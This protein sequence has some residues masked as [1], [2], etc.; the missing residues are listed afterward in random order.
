MN[1][2]QHKFSWQTPRWLRVLCLTLLVGM[3]GL[4]AKAQITL[5]S[6]LANNNG[7]AL[8]IGNLYNSNA[9]PILINEIKC[10]TSL[11]GTQTM[12]LWTKP[13]AGPNMGAPGVVSVVDGW[14]L[15]A[16]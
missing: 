10:A 5:E 12:Q 1:K 2:M 3:T 13:V 14:T 4:G 8:I 7:N 11:N 6:T 16:S 9:Y 15:Q